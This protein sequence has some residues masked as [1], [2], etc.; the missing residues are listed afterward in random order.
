MTDVLPPPP[1][2]PPRAGPLAGSPQPTERG[3]GNHAG[4]IL[5]LVLAATLAFTRGWASL[6]FVLAILLMIFLHELGHYVTAKW[7]GMK[8][9][10]FFI[11]FGPRIWSF[12]KGETEY[13][14]KALPLGAY[15]RISGMHNLDPVDPADEDRAYRNKP[16]WRRVSVAVAGSTMHFLLALLLAFAL[17]A[18][19]G[20]PSD[21][22]WHITTVVPGSPAAVAGLA[23]GDKLVVINGVSMQNHTEAVTYIRAHPGE[24]ASISVNRDGRTFETK[25]RLADHNSAGEAV[26]FLGFGIQLELVRPSLGAAFSD[27]GSLYVTSFKNAFTG[28]G[29]F[30]SPRGVTNYVSTLMNKPNTTAPG[31]KPANEDRPISVIGLVDL[32]GDA[33]HAGLPYVL[34]LM[35]LFNVFIGVFNLIPLL[36]LDGGHVAIAVYE[37]LRTRKGQPMYHA[38]ITKLM[39][40]TYAVVLAMGLLFVT[41]AY[42]DITRGI[43]G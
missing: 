30:F 25:A 42:L 39:P 23:A 21:D 26:G 4:L 6:F 41:S 40:L 28:I 15:V 13:G 2:S 33:S 5:L 29:H 9:T 37:R 1:L 38:D 16:F 36:P 3:W 31:G 27:T 8:V 20:K 12:R 14:V 11:G 32:G 19:Y 35:V 18:G 22:H 7:A 43:G 10:Q 34:E 24:Q 17:V